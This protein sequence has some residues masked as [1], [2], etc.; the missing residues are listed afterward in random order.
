MA[1]RAVA[2]WRPWATGI[3]KSRIMDQDG[4]GLATLTDLLPS[5]GLTQD[6]DRALLTELALTTVG[7]SELQGTAK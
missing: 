3:L 7:R 5:L 1:G 2:G 6:G 4:Q